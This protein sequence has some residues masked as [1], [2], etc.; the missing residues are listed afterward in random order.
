[1]RVGVP[2]GPTP[3]PCPPPGLASRLLP[4]ALRGPGAAPPHAHGAALEP[5]AHQRASVSGKRPAAGGRGAG[6]ARDATFSSL[7][8]TDTA[9]AVPFDIPARWG[10]LWPAR[11]PLAWGSGSLRIVSLH[12]EPLSGAGH[13][14]PV[15]RRGDGRVRER[16][17]FGQGHRASGCRP[18]PPGP[19]GLAPGA[20][21]SLVL[22]CVLWTSA[23]TESLGP[24][25]LG[26]SPGPP[27]RKGGREGG[28]DSVC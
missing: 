27:P 28:V 24:L 17:E 9:G 12:P 8:E 18:D 4:G 13:I 25:L 6:H 2:C 19:R 5:P 26:A 22:Q 20:V 1:M 10:L 11:G 21:L 15:P 7:S 16:E 14:A 23:L 3:P